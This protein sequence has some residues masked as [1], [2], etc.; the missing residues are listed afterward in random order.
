M[1]KRH[2]EQTLLSLMKGYPVITITGPRQSGK[3]TLSKMACPHMK[4]V[5]LENP[6]TRD[7]AENDTKA[8][9]QRYREGAIF[10]EVQRVPKL[11]SYLQEIVDIAK[12]PGQFILT[13]S[14][15][16]G[17]LS[18]ITQS[19]AGRT[20]FIK[21]LPFSLHELYTT[22]ELKNITGFDTVLFTGLYPP[23]H[24]RH[25]DPRIWYANYTTSYIERDVR[26]LVNIRDLSTFQRFVK[27]CAG[28]TGQLVN[29][30]DMAH[31]AGISHNTARS[32]ISILEASYII[33]L[34]QPHHANFNKRIIKTPKLYFHDTGLLCWLLSIHNP[35][36]LNI[37]SMR[38]S[39]FENFVISELLKSFYNQGLPGNINFWRDRSGNEIDCLLEQGEHLQPYEIK[40]G[41][42]FNKDFT[43]GLIKWEKIAENRSVR[44]MLIYGG[45]DCFE[46]QHINIV[47]WKSRDFLYN[48]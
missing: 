19:L 4:Y 33:Y 13:G 37:H 12:K 1:I 10:D 48:M 18:D 24:D 21:L 28:R 6:E 34:L 22:S 17:L 20:A 47:S 7:M 27:L 39:I 15:Q 11:V 31:D 38:G 23:V 8:F 16:F 42:T 35:E 44:P 9:L 3:T 14:Q 5:S 46:F 30:S 26:Q 25:L 45:D 43:T 2:A 32:W 36:E 41:Q 40:S 29:L